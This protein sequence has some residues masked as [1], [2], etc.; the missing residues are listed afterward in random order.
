[1]HT[2]QA[3]DRHAIRAEVARRGSTLTAIALAAGLNPGSCR[4]A[5]SKCFPAADRAIAD[6]LSIPL[7]ELWPDRYDRDGQRLTRRRL[8]PSK[9]GRVPSRRNRVA[10]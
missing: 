9:P 1:M 4:A 3:W 6:F 7:F 5:L 10:A 2:M 8:K